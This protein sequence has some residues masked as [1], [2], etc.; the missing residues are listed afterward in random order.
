MR[1]VVVSPV[2]LFGEA[3]CA[4]LQSLDRVE[5]VQAECNA[6]ELEARIAAFH[7]NV[8][9][10]DI[11]GHDVIAAA[12]SVRARCPDVT[13]VAV[14]VAEVAEE[15]IACADA[16]F[17][18]YIPR[19]ASAEEMISIVQLAL[20]GET[21]CDRRIARSLF[22]ELARRGPM[23]TSSGPDECLTPREVEI[24][25]ML[26][27]G[28]SNK[29]IARELHL[30]VATIKNHVHSAL[31]K[32]QVESRAQVANVLLDNPWVFRFP[33]NGPAALGADTRGV[34]TRAPG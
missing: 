24:A 1:V 18:A 29:E 21:V 15:V 3:I 25:R 22:E 20:Q 28:L 11:T 5:A 17:A 14:A 23:T 10:F 16:G 31:T 2:R 32:L 30:S 13:T 26:G 19:D 33:G 12:K 8:A 27:R 7:A 34:G 9:L 4:F 6:T